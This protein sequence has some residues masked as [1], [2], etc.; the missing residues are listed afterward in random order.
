MIHAARCDFNSGSTRARIDRN[1]EQFIYWRK[2]PRAESSVAA[3]VLSRIQFGHCPRF[4]LQRGITVVYIG[5]PPTLFVDVHR[6]GQRPP[7]L[8]LYRTLYPR[9][10]P[11][12]LAPAG[13]PFSPASPLADLFNPWTSRNFQFFRVPRQT[14]LPEGLAPRR[15]VRST[16]FHVHLHDSE[17]RSVK[18]RAT[19][20]R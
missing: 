13:L 4:H 5:G 8:I 17:M 2:C 18:L 10:L 7:L 14:R 19:W 16:K 6:L 11:P 20:R 15:F 9:P 12:P 3:P 1:V